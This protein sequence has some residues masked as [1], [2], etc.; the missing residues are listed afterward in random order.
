MMPRSLPAMYGPGWMGVVRMMSSEPS[1]R[2]RLTAV[3]LML[4]A[5]RTIT[6]DSAATTVCSAVRKPSRVSAPV[7]C[8]MGSMMP[9]RMPTTTKPQRPTSAI[10]LVPRSWLSRQ[11]M[12]LWPTRMAVRPSAFAACVMRRHHGVLTVRAPSART[13]KALATISASEVM[14][15]SRQY[16]RAGCSIHAETAQ[17]GCSMAGAA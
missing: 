7:R 8:R 15:V 11:A 9:P 17:P 4:S 1:S 2:S 6:T 13:L 12:G 3:A 14:M 5:V 10:R 16:V